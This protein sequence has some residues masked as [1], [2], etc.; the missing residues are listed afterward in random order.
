[1]NPANRDVSLSAA[2]SALQAAMNVWNSQSGTPFRFSYAGQVNDTT[3]AHDTRSVI[4]FRQ[5]TNGGAIASTYAWSVNGLLVESDIVFWDGG[6]KFFTGSSGCSSGV[7]V[8]DIAAHELGH[9]LG[10][11][12][13]SVG[14]ATMYGSYG[15]CSQT[16]RTLSS[17]DIAGAQKLYG[18]VSGSGGTTATNTAP[19]VTI[20]SPVNGVT[21]T[22]GTLVTF[23]GYASDTQQGNLTSFLVWR[24]NLLGQIGTGGSFTRSLTAGTH[25]ITATAIDSGGLTTQRSITVYA[26]AAPAPTT[27]TQARLTARGYKVKGLQKAD[28]AWS[29]LT[30][31][32]VY[33]YR[34]GAK[35][36]TTANDGSVT[37]A[38]NKNGKGSYTYKVCAAGTSTCTN[39][40]T[41]S[42]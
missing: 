34:N 6:F 9:A 30:A 1:V 35:I 36:S 19:S 28:L 15:A 17:D 14:D 24:S 8:E 16:Q 13:S 11:S 12:H 26:V 33:V 5:A 31:T 39:Q 18:T 37:D 22:A 25:A 42:F 21:V 23:A 41:V 27:T 38:I 7:Y 29:G 20:T 32:S 10:L 40:A 3:T 4:V 2:I